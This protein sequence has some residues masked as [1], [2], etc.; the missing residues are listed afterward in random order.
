MHA[1]WRGA[2]A[3]RDVDGGHAQCM[4]AGGSCML[5]RTQQRSS[6]SGVYDVF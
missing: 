6:C 4:A 1:Q 5:E 3:G 2:T